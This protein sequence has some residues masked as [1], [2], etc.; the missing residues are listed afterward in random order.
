MKIRTPEGRCMVCKDN[1]EPIITSYGPTTYHAIKRL[2]V[3]CDTLLEEREK[4]SKETQN[5]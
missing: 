1:G 4:K 5:V 3:L 2:R